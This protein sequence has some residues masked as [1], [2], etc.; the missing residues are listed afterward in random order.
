MR[1]HVVGIRGSLIHTHKKGTPTGSTDWRSRKNLG[2][3]LTL[4]R[5][6]VQIWGFYIFSSITTEIKFQ[7]FSDN[8]EDI[9]AFTPKAKRLKTEKEKQKKREFHNKFGD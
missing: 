5:K 3:P 7:V 9:R 8:P 2:V 4:A 6:F 1:T